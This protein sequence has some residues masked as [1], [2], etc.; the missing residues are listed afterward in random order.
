VKVLSLAL[1]CTSGGHENATPGP[2]LD[3]H[4][5]KPFCLGCEPKAIVTTWKAIVTTWKAS[6]IFINVIHA[7]TKEGGNLAMSQ[8]LQPLYLIIIYEWNMLIV[9]N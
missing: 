4:L 9:I 6:T 7:Q 1:F 5:C 3:P 2:S 8:V